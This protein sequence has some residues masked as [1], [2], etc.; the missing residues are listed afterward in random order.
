MNGDVVSHELA[1][2]FTIDADGKVADSSAHIVTSPHNIS[3]LV[4]G[5]QEPLDTVIDL[6]RH[7]FRSGG[8]W[9]ERVKSPTASTAS[10]VTKGA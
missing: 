2:Q 8:G 6:L 9:C 1:R 10:D 7:H 3:V 4:I 5:A